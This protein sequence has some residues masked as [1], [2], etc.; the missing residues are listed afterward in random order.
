MKKAEFI[1]RVLLIMNEVG[2]QDT[3]T[4][5]ASGADS[6]QI[7]R[8][9]EGAYVDAW[10]RCISVMPKAWF[11]NKS[12]KNARIIPNINDGIGMVVIPND[13]YLLTSFKMQGWAKP[14]YNASVENERTSVV[15]TNEY[16]RGSWIRPCATLKNEFIEDENKVMQVLNYYS[17][18]KGLSN[19]VIAEAIYV[20]VAVPLSD[21]KYNATPAIDIGIDQRIYE[22]LAYLTASSVFTI[23]EKHNISKALEEKVVQMF[24]GFKSVKGNDTTIVQ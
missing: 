9:I 4:I 2:S 6:T 23:L 20:P 22:P 16:T 12:F 10:R 5:F 3:E 8:Y 15:N 21:P 7:D 14:I 1:N 18:P 24:P 11:E 19:H 17:L 13:F